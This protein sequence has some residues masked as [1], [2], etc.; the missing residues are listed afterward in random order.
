MTAKNAT[1]RFPLTLLYDAGCPVCSLEM[2]HLRERCTDGSL[3]FVDI[4]APGFDSAAWDT[5]Q[6]ELMARIH[7][8]RPDGTHLLGLAALREAY[9]AAG[10]GHWLAPTGWRGL[11]GPADAAYERFARDRQRLSRL[12]APLIA[13]IRTWRARRTLRHMAACQGGA[14]GIETTGSARR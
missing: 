9:A 11:A 13:R 8:V 10:L 14:C 7:G 12:A 6:T 2:D 3:C 5:T 1:E 4:T